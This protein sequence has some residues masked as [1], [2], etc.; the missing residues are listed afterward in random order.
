VNNG[1]VAPYAPRIG[2]EIKYYLFFVRKI[3]KITV[4]NEKS[5]FMIGVLKYLF[6]SKTTKYL[7]Y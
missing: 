2:E 5:Y 6:L 4:E 1:A 3:K 7:L